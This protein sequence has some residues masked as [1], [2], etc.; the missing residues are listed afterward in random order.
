[1]VVLWAASVTAVFGY[2][3]I[4][5]VPPILAPLATKEL[6]SLGRS[7]YA[8]VGNLQPRDWSEHSRNVFAQTVAAVGG[9]LSIFE[10]TS[11][12]DFDSFRERLRSW[13]GALPRPCSLIAAN[14]VTAD[15]V[16]RLLRNMRIKV[17][18]DVAVIGI[19]NDSL[20][21]ENTMPTLTS[22]APD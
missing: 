19:D 2:Y 3:A 5:S 8:F 12:Q 21:C 11:A 14:D 9:K 15:I 13:L 20:I 17:P 18:E 4:P 16:L 10:N 22:V 7:N 1:M 6:I